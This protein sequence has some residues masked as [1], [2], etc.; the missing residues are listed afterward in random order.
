M[1]IGL[2]NHSDT[3]GGASVVSVRLLEALRA[4][5]AD[6]SMLVV[7][8][9]G[10]RPYV[11]LAGNALSRKLPFLAEHARIFASNGF[12]RTDLFAASVATDGLPLS[13]HP[14]VRDADAVLLN[15]VNQGMLS[16]SEIGRMA[17]SG[18]RVFWTMHDMWNLTGVC[19]HAGECGGYLREPGCGHCPLMH[20]RAGASDLSRRTWLRKR[21]LYSKAGITFVAVSSWL[22]DKCRRSTLMH[23]QRVEVV[24]NAFPVEDFYT[25]PKNQGAFPVLPSDKKLIVMGAERLDSPVK[26]LRYAVEALNRLAGG[27][28]D[29]AMAV[30]FGGLRDPH[31]LDGLRLPYVSL[32]TISD[33]A[34]LRELYSRASAVLSSSLYETLPGTLIEGQAAGA[35]PVSFGEGGQ[36]DII[37]H[38]RTGYIAR[39]LDTADLAEGLRVA[40]SQPVPREVLR[41]SVAARFSAEAVAGRYLSLIGR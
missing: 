33:P 31:A 29:D 30:F 10:D 40:L 3:R 37:T 28:C 13:R 6:A 35:F 38:G 39:Y 9:A 15:W 34:A 4:L 32:G 41:E 27:G 21:E 36:P 26:G 18:K 5:G 25:V 2:I 23:G 1:K 17:A 12:T 7:R 20:G 8:K 19:H 14:L 11:H 16:L 22:A 24:P